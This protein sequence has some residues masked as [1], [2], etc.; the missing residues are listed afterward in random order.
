MPGGMARDAITKLRDFTDGMSNTS[1][2]AETP[3]RPARY[4]ARRQPAGITVLDGWGWADIDTVSRSINGASADGTQTNT[5]GGNSPYATVVYGRCAINCTN[6]SE[7]YSWHVGGVQSSMADGSVRFLSENM[8][9][10]VLIAIMT[11][12]G[13]EVV[14]EF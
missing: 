4:N 9:A 1:L 10:S 13:G 8:D 11:R 2:I 3:G 12:A 5:T 7:L 14:G 6:S